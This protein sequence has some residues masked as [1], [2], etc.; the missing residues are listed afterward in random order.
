MVQFIVTKNSVTGEEKRYDAGSGF[1]GLFVFAGYEPAT[2]LFKDQLEL[3]E[4]G[5]LVTDR[6][7][8]TSMPGVYGAGDV[9]VKELRQVVTAVSDGALAATCMEKYLFSM[10]EKLGLE[11]TERA[12]ARSKPAG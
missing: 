12:G 5:Y 6:R 11:K 7:Q 8:Q 10:Y 1:F 4:M 9:C 3:N 2:A